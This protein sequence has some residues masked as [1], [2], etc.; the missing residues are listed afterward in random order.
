MWILSKLKF[1]QRVSSWYFC[2]YKRSCFILD[3]RGVPKLSFDVSSTENLASSQE[4]E[5]GPTP[6][7]VSLNCSTVTPNN[8]TLATTYN[9]TASSGKSRTRSNDPT[10]DTSSFNPFKA[11]FGKDT[12]KG[13]RSNYFWLLLCDIPC[14]CKWC[15]KHFE[16][17]Y[18]AIKCM[19]KVIICLLWYIGYNS[20]FTNCEHPICHAGSDGHV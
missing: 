14:V 20:T 16:Y 8:N 10:P 17:F 19:D 12:P 2:Y 3:C 11:S 5:R 7:N 18:I 1:P 6:R 15:C 9:T 4:G 13:V